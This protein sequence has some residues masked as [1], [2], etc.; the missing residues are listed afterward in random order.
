MDRVKVSIYSKIMVGWIRRPPR[1]TV[2]LNFIRSSVNYHLKRTKLNN[3]PVSVV[4][5]I[6][7]NCNYSC[8]FCYNKE[9]LNKAP[10]EE[11]I[12]TL[13]DLERF[14][15]TPYGKKCLRIAFMGGEPF[16]NENI[17]DLI[18]R[19]KKES[20]VTNIVSNASLLNEEMVKKIKSSGLDV[21]GLSLYPNNKSEVESSVKLFNQYNINYWV[22]TVVDA[23]KIGLVE[24]TIKFAISIGIKNLI[25]SNYNSYFNDAHDK[26]LYY[27]DQSLETLFKMLDHKY[28]NELNISWPTLVVGATKQERKKQCTLPFNYIHLDKTGD[29]APCCYRYPRPEYGNIYSSEGWNT[30]YNI[31]LRKNMLSTDVALDECQHCENLYQNLY[32]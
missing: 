24:N 4:L 1:M 3:Y 29:L 15:D 9:I 5:Y 11:E 18:E 28:G 17:F 23:T 26:P 12:Y 32:F 25:L 22:Q 10:I 14:F 13:E 20:K 2:I 31:E 7:K 27:G 6:N 21:I 16:L 19:C 8:N 30:A